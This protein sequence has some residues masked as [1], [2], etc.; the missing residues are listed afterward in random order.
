MIFNVESNNF[1]YS[2]KRYY[3]SLA[4]AICVACGLIVSA[5]LS[6]DV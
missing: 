5:E 4:F 1:V 2:K 6:F 3:H